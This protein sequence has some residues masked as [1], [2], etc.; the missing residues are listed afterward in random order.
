[1]KNLSILLIIAAL[2]YS[3]GSGKHAPVESADQLIG[4][5]EAK[6]KKTALIT[7]EADSIFSIQFPGK[8]VLAGKYWL[9][10]SKLTILNDPELGFCPNMEGTY[11]ISIKNKKRLHF[12]LVDDECRKRSKRINL[13]WKRK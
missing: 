9:N 13:P 3:C 6:A 7:F 11:K 4:Q 5:W 8:P 10:D 12:E 1:M 2:V